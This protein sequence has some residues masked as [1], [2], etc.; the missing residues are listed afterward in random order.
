MLSIDCIY[1]LY[2]YIY[3]YVVRETHTCI[4]VHERV[5]L[6]PGY[7]I[8]FVY[9]IPLFFTQCSFLLAW[10]SLDIYIASSRH[11]FSVARNIRQ[12]PAKECGR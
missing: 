3:I 2:S 6:M 12:A 7:F 10:R 11:K 1:T 5:P 4:H 8:S 9:F